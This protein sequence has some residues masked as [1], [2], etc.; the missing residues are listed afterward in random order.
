MKRLYSVTILVSL[1]FLAQSC[2]LDSSDDSTE[3]EP[4]E[5]STAPTSELSHMIEET[6]SD[7]TWDYFE[8]NLN[9]RTI[10]GGMPYWDGEIIVSGFQVQNGDVVNR[11]SSE[12]ASTNTDVLSEG[13][14]SEELFPG[15][16]WMSGKTW[17]QGIRGSLVKKWFPGSKWSPSQIEDMAITQTDLAEDQTMVVVYTHVAGSTERE[18]RTQPFGIIFNSE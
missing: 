9:I 5:F 8:D 15:S 18:V 14:S 17:V 2:P 11:G 3:P 6:P 16:K 1:L 7:F 10:P 12:A 13:I 4:L